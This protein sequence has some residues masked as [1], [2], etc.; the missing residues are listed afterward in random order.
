MPPRPIL[1]APT[2]AVTGQSVS[3]GRNVASIMA[4]VRGLGVGDTIRI[5]TSVWSK[6][7]DIRR[8]HAAQNNVH[9]KFSIQRVLGGG[10]GLWNAGLQ[11]VERYLRS[12]PDSV[13]YVRR[14]I[15]R[16]EGNPRNLR[17]IADDL[18]RLQIFRYI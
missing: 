18:R 3:L 6:D 7:F 9:P 12:L 16:R 5:T 11:D 17:P 15:T 2:R 13:Q 10:R 14:N 1:H 8:I 4:A